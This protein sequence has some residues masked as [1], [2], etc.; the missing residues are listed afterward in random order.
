[1]HLRG[2]TG[3]GNPCRLGEVTCQV[4]EKFTHTEHLRPVIQMD[5]Y[6]QNQYLKLPRAF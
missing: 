6:L 2:C 1:M 5:S 4:I 3:D